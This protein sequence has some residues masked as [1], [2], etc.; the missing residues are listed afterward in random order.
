[1]SASI[2]GVFHQE[3]VNYHLKPAFEYQVQAWK[4]YKKWKK[5]ELKI[6]LSFVAYAILACVRL[7]RTIAATRVKATILFA[8]E[9]GRSEIF[10]EKLSKR[11]S[12]SF[13]VQVIRMDEY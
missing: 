13:T 6:R 7:M 2:T 3:M 9:T 4:Q 5:V 12:S 1:M 10:A 8:T 11:L